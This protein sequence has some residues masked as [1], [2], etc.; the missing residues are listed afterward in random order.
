MPPARGQDC[1]DDKEAATDRRSNRRARVDA[2][3]GEKES[4]KTQATKTDPAVNWQERGLAGFPLSRNEVTHP[5]DTKILSA[6]ARFDDSR[7]M[8]SLLAPIPDGDALGQMLA[9]RQ[10]GRSQAYHAETRTA[11]YVVSDGKTVQ[12]F[13]VTN[14]TLEQAAAV[15]AECDSIKLW[16]PR[17]FQAAVERA[18]GAASDRVQ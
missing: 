12:C 17:A 14:L 15:A 8:T 18:L 3:E 10:P 7:A 9:E 5:V 1:A 2:A 4:V 6:M 16:E 11:R 13:T